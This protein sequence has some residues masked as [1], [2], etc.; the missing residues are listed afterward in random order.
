M[1]YIYILKADI[2]KAVA[3]AKAAFAPGSAWRSTPPSHRSRLLHKVAD[4]IERDTAY[5][6]VSHT[7][8]TEGSTNL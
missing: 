8:C 3:A 6:A 1:I 2:D 7:I 4:L 5:L